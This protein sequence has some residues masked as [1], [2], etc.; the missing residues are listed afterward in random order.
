MR[1]IKILKRLLLA[2]LLI[3]ILIAGGAWWLISYVAPDE[4]LTMEYNSIDVAQKMLDMVKRMEPVLVLTEAEVNDLIKKN[5]TKQLS[6]N[7]K[8][9]RDFPFADHFEIAGAAFELGDGQMLA[10]IQLNYRERIPIELQIMYTVV[11][12]NPN[13][14]LLPESLSVKSINLPVSLLE[15]IETSLDLPAGEL[16]QVEDVQVGVDGI[17]VRFK[18]QFSR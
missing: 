9:S 4:K 2:A 8:D 11:W 18:M 10:R 6:E 3:I 12:D 14:V 17:K 16:V 7:L 13:I 15:P 5:M 1:Q